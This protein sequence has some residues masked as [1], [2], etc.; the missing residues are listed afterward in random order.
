[1]ALRNASPP[2]PRGRSLVIGT[3]GHIDHGKSTLVKAL[4]GTDPDR[5]KEEKERGITIDLGFAFLALPGGD[6]LMFV[7]VPG[8]ERFVKN[9]L[10]GAGGVDAAL[11]VVAADESVMPQT[12]EHLD[13]L[14]LLAIPRGI[15][16]LTK[17]GL[18]DAETREVS[19]MEVA[20]LLKG[21]FLH[22]APIVEVDAIS[23]EGMGLLRGE[24]GRLAAAPRRSD[25]P[26]V[27]RLPVDRVFAIKGF[28]TVVT[29]TCQ[30][31][32]V[33][34]GSTVEI[35]PRGKT[36]RL[37]GIEVAGDAAAATASGERTGLN[38]PDVEVADVTRGDVV[39]PLGALAPAVALRAI[40]SVLPKASAPIRARQRVH[41][42][43]HA[44]EVLARVRFLE[45]GRQQIAP[46]SSAAV[47]L[48]LESPAVAVW[49]DRFVLR[50][51]SPLV[52][53]AGGRVLLADLEG[54]PPARPDAALLAALA[55]DDTATAAEALLVHA[56]I[57]GIA[58]AELVRRL[59]LVRERVPAPRDAGITDAGRLVARGALDAAADE[60]VRHVE[61]HHRRAPQE[62]GA[63]REAARGAL[64]PRLHADLFRAVV[65]RAEEDRRLVLD[66]DVLRLPGFTVATTAEE[67][68]HL[69][70][71][72]A[73]F[74]DAGSNPPAPAEAC[75]SLGIPEAQGERLIVLLCREGALRRIGGGLIFHALVL[76]A[77][78]SRVSALL[79][80]KPT[81][82]V[83]EFKDLA[84]TSRKYAIPLLEHL[85]SRRVTERKGD[86]RRILPRRSTTP[87]APTS[88]GGA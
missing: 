10:A 80:G 88:D 87:E 8:H 81:I 64:F 55:G 86:L 72:E 26:R 61:K 50:R 24:L 56:G 20:E 69:A 59:G 34:L 5:L 73:V 77:I 19:R 40:V 21:T 76:D 68:A 54:G 41:V 29:G 30:G 51:Y 28:G 70:R 84:G 7:D 36:S 48:L 16:V 6:R 45:K 39:A 43:L 46:G 85:D 4:T 83:P 63:G 32:P 42:H 49:G 35:L 44:A 60:L 71:L 9:M 78:A 67:A 75:R 13:I 58:P 31:Q 15:V 52:T 38:L 2:G 74:R 37:R 14:T 53:I 11:L 82:S 18:A 33:A 25:D 57:G 66:G 17:C 27:F 79:P 22:G 65:A 23:G 62:A 12:E 3:A 1:M 47:T